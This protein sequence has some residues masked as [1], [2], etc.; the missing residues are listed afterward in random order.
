MGLPAAR[1]FF[2]VSLLFF[3]LF[4]G[5]D[6]LFFLFLC[7]FAAFFPFIHC[8]QELI[9]QLLDILGVFVSGCIPESVIQL[10]LHVIHGAGSGLLE[11]ILGIIHIRKDFTHFALMLEFGF[12]HLYEIHERTDMS[13]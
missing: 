3:F 8:L 10:F 11:K 13:P 6:F 1:F 4:F 2:G 9:L 5:L 7:K 12:T